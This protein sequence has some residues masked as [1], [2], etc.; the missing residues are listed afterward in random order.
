[1]TTPLKIIWFTVHFKQCHLTPFFIF[2]YF[3]HQNHEPVVSHVSYWCSFKT[4]QRQIWII[5]GLHFVFLFLFFIKFYNFKR[6]KKVCLS[7][8]MW[9][10][11]ESATLLACCIWEHLHKK[12][13]KTHLCLSKRSC[14]LSSLFLQ[15]DCS[16]KFRSLFPSKYSTFIILNRALESQDPRS[17]EA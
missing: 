14:F 8:F 9:Q 10:R 11:T 12:K 13:K 5:E 15:D 17:H 1:M 4:L 6:H 3:T 2:F 7:K 16:C